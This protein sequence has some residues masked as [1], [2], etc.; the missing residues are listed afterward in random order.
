[1]VGEIFVELV[2]DVDWCFVVVVL[3]EGSD[4]CVGGWNVLVVEDWFDCI[5]WEL[6]G[7]F[8]DF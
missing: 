8:V 6:V 4:E 1:M 2:E 3:D 7:D 5:G